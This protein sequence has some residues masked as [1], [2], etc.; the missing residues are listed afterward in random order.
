MLPPS[1]NRLVALGIATFL[2]IVLLFTALQHGGPSIQ[3]IKE[4]AK[5]AA[6]TVTA[7][8]QEQQ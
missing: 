2:V 8:T 7:P 4:A 6:G 1:C 3:T 5:N